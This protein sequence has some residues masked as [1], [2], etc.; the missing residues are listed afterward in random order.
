MALGGG[1]VGNQQFSS[2]AEAGMLGT[3]LTWMQESKGEKIIIA[4]TNDLNLPAAMLRAER[5]D[6]IWFVDFPTFS[7]RRDIIKIQNKKWNAE[8]P[9]DDDDFVNQ[10]EGWTGAEIGQLAKDSLFEP[11]EEAIYS[12][13]LIKDIKPEEIKIIQKFGKTVRKANTPEE[14]KITKEKRKI[15]KV[16]DDFEDLKHTIKK[17]FLKRGN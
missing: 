3:F 14:V 4:T 13:S 6:S 16:D 5:W 9:F 11:W 7:E 15:S 10:L 1:N 8:L 2:N 12:I 17:K